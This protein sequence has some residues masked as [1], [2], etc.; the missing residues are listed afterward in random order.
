MSLPPEVAELAAAIIAAAR[1][2]AATIQAWVRDP[3]YS[4]VRAKRVTAP[5]LLII[6]DGVYIGSVN[7]PGK[8]GLPTRWFVPWEDVIHST[9]PLPGAPIGHPAR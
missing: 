5:L 1:P 4:I 2:P 8:E 6:G 3:V 7:T 9:I